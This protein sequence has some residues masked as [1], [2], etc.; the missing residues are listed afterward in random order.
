MKKL[1]ILFALVLLASCD[2]PLF[3]L[4]EE[5][6]IS[7]ENGEGVK[8]SIPYTIYDFVAYKKMF[9]YSDFESMV[10]KSSVEAKYMCNYKSTY[11]PK[12]ISLSLSNDTTTVG[13]Y[14]SAKNAFG[15]GDNFY[16]FSLFKGK[17]FIES[18]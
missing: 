13:V 12:S 2:E 18:F 9:S 4:Q 15:V 14:L 7:L 8:K 11:E 17:V 10:I 6:K 3:G 5:G 1:I 16:V